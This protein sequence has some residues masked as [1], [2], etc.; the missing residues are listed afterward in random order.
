MPTLTADDIRALVDFILELKA[1]QEAAESLLRQY[2]TDPQTLEQARQSVYANLLSLP[3]ASW[4]RLHLQQSTG[5]DLEDL[6][7]V[8]RSR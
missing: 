4:I 3:K 8:L 5:R 7:R 2:Q 6:V 1:R